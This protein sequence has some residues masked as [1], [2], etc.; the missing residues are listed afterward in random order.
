MGLIE[1]YLGKD[2]VQRRAAGNLTDEEVRAE[3][4]E[5]TDA[6]RDL[7]ELISDSP[8]GGPAGGERRPTPEEAVRLRDQLDSVQRR[9][10][11]VW[12]EYSRRF[13]RNL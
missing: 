11:G 1:D 3:Y 9:A 6:Q 12:P 4:G 13:G 5:L 10:A 2:F 7:R 8:S